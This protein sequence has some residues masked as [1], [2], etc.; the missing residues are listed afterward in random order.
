MKSLFHPELDKL[1]KTYRKAK[2]KTKHNKVLVSKRWQKIRQEVFRAYG[3]SCMSCKGTENIHVYHLHYSTLGKERVEDL[4]PLCSKCHLIIT[5]AK[6]RMSAP[7]KEALRLM[8][9]FRE[10]EEEDKYIASL[11][12]R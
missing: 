12:E 1:D 9:M 4:I 8:E 6:G 10:I 3:K 11:W 7:K 5:K 2:F